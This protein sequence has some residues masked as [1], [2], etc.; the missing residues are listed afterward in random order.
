MDY[1]EL[2][3][4]SVAELR[5]EAAKIEGLQGYTQMNKQHLLEAIC[6]HLN[7]PMHEHHAVSGIDK[8]GVKAKIQALKAT[9]DQAVA[10]KDR[11]LLT[12]TLRKIH[13]LKRQLR[14]AAV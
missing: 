14:R 2:K 10:A 7:L 9:R 5:E 13:R 4:K 6:K 11:T 1:H 3:K 8:A 12:R